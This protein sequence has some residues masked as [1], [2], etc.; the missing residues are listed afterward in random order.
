MIFILKMKN[1]TV[2][3][4]IHFLASLYKLVFLTNMNVLVIN[5]N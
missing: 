1:I 5:N 3:I 2:P 4:K